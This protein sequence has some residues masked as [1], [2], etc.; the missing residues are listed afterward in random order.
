MILC[1][2]STIVLVSFVI[3]VG[4]VKGKADTEECQYKYYTGITVQYGD[5][6]WSIA[7]QYADKEHYDHLSYIKEVKSINH[8]QDEN[9]I[10]AGKL[11]IVP[12]YSSQYISD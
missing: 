6:L 10:I 3:I 9:E 12:Y 2:V 7:D 11:L 5:S 1:M 8:I 4:S